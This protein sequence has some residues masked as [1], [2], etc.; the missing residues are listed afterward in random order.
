MESDG[1][2]GGEQA[3]AD[4]VGVAES[5][6]GLWGQRALKRYTSAMEAI[7]TGGMHHKPGLPSR[8]VTEKRLDRNRQKGDTQKKGTSGGEGILLHDAGGDRGDDTRGQTDF[9]KP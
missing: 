1:S 6:W 8:V 2:R 3:C 5:R 9:P 4:C 7:D